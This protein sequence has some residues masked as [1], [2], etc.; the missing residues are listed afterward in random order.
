MRFFNSSIQMLIQFLPIV[1]ETIQPQVSIHYH[2]D[3]SSDQRFNNNNNNIYEFQQRCNAINESNNLMQHLKLKVLELAYSTMHIS[4]FLCSTTD[5]PKHL[6]AQKHKLK[7]NPI[8]ISN[9]K[10]KKVLSICI[11]NGYLVQESDNHQNQTKRRRPQ[12][13]AAK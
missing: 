13:G 12:R 10:L 3:K 9:N 1:K 6:H 11:H 5:F 8:I 2:R 4:C 7:K